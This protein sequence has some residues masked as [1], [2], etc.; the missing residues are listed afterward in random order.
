MAANA[1]KSVAT[2]AT[3][4]PV[5]TRISFGDR[6][7]NLR[8]NAVDVKEQYLKARLNLPAS[9]IA[10]QFADGSEIPFVEVLL[11]FILFEAF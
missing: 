2:S 3:P 5:T 4:V 9:P 1:W 10:F 7:I 6:T 8:G 11:R